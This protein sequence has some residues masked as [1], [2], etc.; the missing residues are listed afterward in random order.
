MIVNPIEKDSATIGS[1]LQYF[2]L[3]YSYASYYGAIFIEIN[4]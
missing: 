3:F 1:D 2:I 4:T